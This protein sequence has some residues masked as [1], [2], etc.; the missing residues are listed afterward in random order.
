M[1]SIEHGPRLTRAA[2]AEVCAAQSHPRQGEQD[3]S[4]GRAGE[5]YACYPLT[6]LRLTNGEAVVTES[7]R[8]GTVR[9]RSVQTLFVP[10]TSQAAFIVDM[11]KRI[12][13]VTCNEGYSVE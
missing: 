1:R 5:L 3:K 6:A 12:H 8:T 10:S 7:L 9:R 11:R 4:S 13:V 2:I